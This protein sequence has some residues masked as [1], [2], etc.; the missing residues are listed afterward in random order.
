MSPE[1]LSMNRPE[2]SEAAGSPPEEMNV[3]AGPHSGP[4]PAPSDFPNLGGEPPL[5]DAPDMESGPQERPVGDEDYIVQLSPESATTPPQPP[6]PPELRT[7]RH[8]RPEFD[9]PDQE[10]EQQEVLPA[11]RDSFDERF[12][13]PEPAGAGEEGQDESR[14]IPDPAPSPE[15]PGWLDE[16]EQA[17]PWRDR[18]PGPDD[19]TDQPVYPVDQPQIARQPAPEPS[20][21]IGQVEIQVEAPPAPPAS[22]R[23]RPNNAGMASR[24][25]L[26]GL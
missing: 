18:D 5:A 3:E 11:A 12:G 8:F 14:A 20:V 6:E 2:Q 15:R 19:S 24:R 1:A 26:R 9:H 13:G 10:L 22:A 7:D 21:Q 23:I 17:V 4:G 25:Y 16:L